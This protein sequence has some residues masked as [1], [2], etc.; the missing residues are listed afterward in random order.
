MF[1]FTILIVSLVSI[2]G[3]DFNCIISNHRTEIILWTLKWTM[4][5]C[6]EFNLV[7]DNQT[8]RGRSRV[9][10][11]IIQFSQICGVLVQAEKRS[12]HIAANMFHECTE[13]FLL[14]AKNC[15]LTGIAE[16]AEICYKFKSSTMKFPHRIT[17]QRFFFR[18]KE[19]KKLKIISHLFASFVASFFISIFINLRNKFNSFVSENGLIRFPEKRF[20]GSR[21]TKASCRQSQLSS[22]IRT[23]ENEPLFIML[24]CTI[25]RN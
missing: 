14:T 2:S 17:Q 9:H 18:S 12:S 4:V 21:R 25:H 16:T 10:G 8:C 1:K 7:R 13:K 22:I 23:I 3:D 19:R 11:K 6:F 5:L 24:H 15:Q 20:C